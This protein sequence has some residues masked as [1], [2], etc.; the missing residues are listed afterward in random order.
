MS[1]VTGVLVIAGT[2][3]LGG[4]IHT[5]S[6]QA[7]G[8]TSQTTMLVGFLILSLIAAVVLFYGGSHLRGGRRW[9]LML[10]RIAGMA[11]LLLLLF[12][13]VLAIIQ[14]A[15]EAKPVLAVV[16]DAS[17]SM[18]YN[19]AANQPNRYRQAAIAVE[20]TLAP[21]LEKAYRLSV[22]AYDTKHTAPLEQPGR[23]GQDCSRRRNH[24]PGARLWPTAITSAGNGGGAAGGG[25]EGAGKIAGA[26]LFS[27]G[28][29][30]GPIAVEAEH[31]TLAVGVP[32]HTVRVGSSDLEPSAVPDIAV[33][34]VE[35]PQTAVVNNQVTL[36]ASIKSTAMSDRTV[37]VSL[38]EKPSGS[39]ETRQYDEQ[40]LVLHSGTMPQTVQL[41]FTPDKVVRATVRVQI[42]VE[43]GERSDV[44]NQQDFSLLVTDPKLSVLYVEERVRPE[45]ESAST[46]GLEQDP[47]F[48]V[49]FAG[50]DN[51]GP[52]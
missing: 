46:G 9:T 20:N 52:F 28:I 38:S 35:G 47:E 23:P 27:D 30:N 2:A 45:V 4:L 26:V 51:G 17:A 5:T 37:R 39:G 19:D 15:D 40:R 25:G 36:T 6:K 10:L 33:V 43:P 31:N 21:R 16:V 13:P 14:G 18:S 7:S 12:R 29:H 42:P 3:A 32:V 50:A 48:D 49:D 1:M 8:D 11:A 22:F 41:K 24:G 34:S 44:R